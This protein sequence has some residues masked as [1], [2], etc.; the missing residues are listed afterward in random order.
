MGIF[1]QWLHSSSYEATKRELIT[2]SYEVIK[3][4]S[5]ENVK[6]PLI[7]TNVC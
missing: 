6:R 3:G 5:G 2:S 4:E 7:K 1:V